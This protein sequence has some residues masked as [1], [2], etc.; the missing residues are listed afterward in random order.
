MQTFLID[1]MTNFTISINYAQFS[2]IAIADEISNVVALGIS[3][4]LVELISSVQSISQLNS[5][6]VN[7]SK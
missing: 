2:I 4:S 3:T 7:L 5:T 1:Y 6:Q